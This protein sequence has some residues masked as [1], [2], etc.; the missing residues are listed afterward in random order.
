MHSSKSGNYYSCSYREMN[1]LFQNDA[2][3]HLVHDNFKSNSKL[4]GLCSY[5]KNK[6]RSIYDSASYIP[7]TIVIQ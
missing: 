5:L 2:F 4:T 7:C 1:K 3:N 6:Q